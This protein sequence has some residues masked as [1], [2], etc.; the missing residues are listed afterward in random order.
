MIERMRQ[1]QGVVGVIGVA[2]LAVLAALTFSLDELPFAAAGRT[3]LTATVT[4]SGGLTTGDPVE[5]AG[6]RAGEVR[7]TSLERGLVLVEFTLDSPI[8]LGQDTRALVRVGNLLGSTYLEIQPDGRG[9]L[10][11]G[12]QIPLRNTKPAYDIVAATSDLTRTTQKI[13]TQQLS[14]AF[15]ALSEVLS[16]APADMKSTVRGLAQLSQ[17]INARDDELKDLLNSS[18][19]VTKALAERSGDIEDLVDDSNQLLHELQR[20]QDAIN[21]LL[22]NTE[23]LANHLRHLATTTSEDLTPALAQLET[24]VGDLR[25]RQDDLRRTVH[26]MSIY[27]RVFNNTVGSGPWFDAFIPNVPDSIRE[28]GD[29]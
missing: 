2:F 6:V 25:V 29:R 27:A 5:I 15:D 26:A 4:D 11:D 17:S 23:R 1:S 16:S 12:D 22:K 28:R 3:T 14:E 8:R 10:T 21:G 20:R 19:T 7:S 18:S 24:V 13:D 9:R